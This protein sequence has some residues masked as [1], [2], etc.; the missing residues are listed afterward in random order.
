M[1]LYSS[2][3]N[4]KNFS[5]AQVTG[6]HPVSRFLPDPT[7]L[8]CFSA[9]CWPPLD[10]HTRQAGALWLAFLSNFAQRWPQLDSHF[11][12]LVLPSWCPQSSPA[13]Q[14]LLP[15]FILQVPSAP[16]KLLSRH[17]NPC[18]SWV[19]QLG[20]GRHHS[21][22]FPLG[23]WHLGGLSFLFASLVCVFWILW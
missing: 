15:H 7:P 12:E 1:S 22:E 23:L 6:F 2:F 20:C 10:F 16:A 9:V 3:W 21:F 11:P 19:A 5:Q 17:Y 13:D 18:S 14:N 4:F 8:L